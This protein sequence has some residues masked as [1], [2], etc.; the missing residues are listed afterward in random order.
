MKDKMKNV[1][2]I[3]PPTRNEWYYYLDIEGNLDG[4]DPRALGDVEAGEFFQ[5]DHIVKWWLINQNNRTH[6]WEFLIDASKYG[7]K[8]AKVFYL[9]QK[10]KMTD[11]DA[12]GYAKARDFILVKGAGGFHVYKHIVGEVKPSRIGR[13]PTAFSAFVDYEMKVKQ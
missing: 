9:L 3:T 2:P 11:E 1:T 13:G 10:W 12:K 5:N 7:A 8:N 4:L 6:A